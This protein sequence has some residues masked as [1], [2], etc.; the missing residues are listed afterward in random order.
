MGLCRNRRL[1]G[2]LGLNTVPSEALDSTPGESPTASSRLETA[3]SPGVE[4]PCGF[5]EACPPW[6]P[7]GVPGQ[8]PR[9]PV[10]RSLASLL[11]PCSS[12]GAHATPC[13]QLG[14]KIVL[15]LAAFQTGVGLT[16]TV[17]LLSTAGCLF[18]LGFIEKGRQF[19]V[20]IIG[21]FIR[22]VSLS[23]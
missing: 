3:G 10:L 19:Q 7:A 22:L 23:L 6:M 5:G 18:A 16:Q 11:S 12:Q 4:V 8:A 2:C 17:N 13:R 21:I 15:V 14:P 20:L 1:A 9:H